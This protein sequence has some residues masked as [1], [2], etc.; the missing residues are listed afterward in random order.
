MSIRKTAQ[1]QIKAYKKQKLTTING[2]A[3]TDLLLQ[4]IDRIG[5]EQSQLLSVKTNRSAIISEMIAY[6]NN[7]KS[8]KEDFN[9][10]LTDIVGDRVNDI[11]RDYISADEAS[12]LYDYK[13]FVNRSPLVSNNQW[14]TG[15]RDLDYVYL[16]NFLDHFKTKTI[17][18]I[19]NCMKKFDSA[20]KF[21]LAFQVTF[22]REFQGLNSEGEIDVMGL[23]F[24][25]FYLQAESPSAVLTVDD[26]EDKIHEQIKYIQ[27]KIDNPDGPS[28]LI[29]HSLNTV[30]LSID[31]FN[32][33]TGKG[34]IKTPEFLA[35]KK[36]CIN[37]NNSKSKTS[38]N[39]CFRHAVIASMRQPTDHVDRY[40]FYDNDENQIFNFDGIMMPA[41]CGSKTFS[42][43]ESNNKGYSLNVYSF[44]VGGEGLDNLNPIYISN[45]TGMNLDIILLYDK[46]DKDRRHYIAIKSFSKLT[47]TDSNEHATCRR[48]LYS[49]SGVGAKQRLTEHSP[50]CQGINGGG[51]QKITMPEPGTLKK[52]KDYHAYHM[53]PFSVYLD[54]ESTLIKK[55]I[56]KGKSSEIINEH[57]A[58]SYYFIVAGADGMIDEYTRFYRGENA[59][60][61]CLLALKEVSELIKPLLNQH[62]EIVMTDDDNFKYSSQKQCYMCETDFTPYK[63][64]T[65]MTNEEKCKIKVRDHDH[66]TGKFRGAAC[67]N[68]NL[69]CKVKNE[70]DV[71][72]HNGKNYDTHLLMQEMH[73]LDE[74]NDFNV[75]ATNSEKYISFS[76][77]HR[78]DEDLEIEAERKLNQAK[79]RKLK[80]KQRRQSAAEDKDPFMFMSLEAEE[81]DEDIEDLDQ[82]IANIKIADKTDS[83]KI[84]FKD[85]CQFLT[86]SLEKLVKN[87][88]K[89][90][91]KN[92]GL[93]ANKMKIDLDLLA[94]KGSYPYS[95]IDDISK[96]ELTEL[97][98]QK[99]FYDDLSNDECSDK[100]YSHAQNVWK[101]ARC[102]NF[103]D[104]HDLYLKT[105]VHLLA[106]VFEN[107][108]RFAHKTYGLDPTYYYTMP[109]LSWGALFNFKDKNGLKPQLELISDPDIYMAFESSL[110]GGVCVAS[111]RHFKANNE[112]CEDY[113]KTKPKTHLRYDDANNLYGW[114]MIQKLPMK[115][116]KYGENYSTEKVLSMNDDADTGALLCVDVEY[117]DDLHDTHADFPLLPESLE[118]KK[119]IMSDYSKLYCPKHYK[120]CKKLVPNLNKKVEYWIHYRNLK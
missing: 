58:N 38:K 15:E 8:V 32:P 10:T 18:I 20:V 86:A 109:G 53:K 72:I 76:I 59:A 113:D 83:M 70:L 62:K 27:N 90:D 74:N 105:D 92:T 97:P 19:S 33:I 119:D 7:I 106:D 110:R 104:Y 55:N 85:S 44:P 100:D 50:L 45:E 101:A 9:N 102:E 12:N 94:R 68:C 88:D 63:T 87:T 13:L 1:A 107:F 112:H 80:A 4:E 6:Q 25:K 31:K 49:F 47:A 65:S 41:I 111:N 14:K 115:N 67:S 120:P 71:Y 82:D 28:N 30:Y 43:F 17:K 34:W 66:H 95:F 29:L 48:C 56:S 42:K 51:H 73:K 60:Y 78:N 96:F 39:D 37:V 16:D 103:G 57:V 36:C 35:N 114:A 93:F 52:F 116:F 79:V 54:F 75:I 81:V 118:I 2:N 5:R 26:I 91:L 23:D 61:H 11:S 22:M 46:D 77:S 98:S 108:R 64:F 99:D 40:G 84:T 89:K 117:P 69:K 24:K 21:K 3:K